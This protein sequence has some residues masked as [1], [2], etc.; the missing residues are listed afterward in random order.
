M[1]SYQHLVNQFT[2][3][4]HFNHLEAIAGWD[5]AVMMPEKGNQARS[6][7]MATL[8]VLSH[9]LMADPHMADWFAAAEAE[10]L[11]K[12]EQ[13]SLREMKRQWS[14]AVA[15]PADLV[16][17]QS[18]AGA[19][20]EHAWRHQR[21]ENDWAG[22]AANL[23]EVVALSRE[24]A[25]CRAEA[26]GLGRYDALLA[27]YEPGMTGDRLDGLFGDLGN[28]LPSMI[29]QVQEHQKGFDIQIPKGPFPISQQKALGLDLMHKLGFDFDRG[30]LDVSVHPFCGGV[31]EDVRITTRYNEMDFTHSLM[32]V[33]HETGHA[34][35]EQ[36]LPVDWMSLPVGQ[37][38]STGI[39]ESQS[40]LMEMQIGRSE[41]FLT[42]I[43]PLILAHLGDQP[44]MALD[45][46]N[47]L[48]RRVQPGKIRVDADE[49]TYPAHIM[50][51][52]EIERDLI[53]GRL[54]VD[55]IPDVWNEKMASYL[56]LDTK[57]DFRNGCMQD[58]HW[59]D[60]SFGYFP[61]Y[62]LGAMYAAQFMAAMRRELPDLMNQVAK[63]ELAP[64]RQWLAERVWNKGCFLETDQLVRE[65]TGEPLNPKWFKEHL[66]QRYLPN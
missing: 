40:L 64:L 17:A 55:H 14:E 49:V 45:N 7:A 47:L 22:F 3:L 34:S 29:Q 44:A 32:G 26:T 33:V 51:R 35:Y 10:S 13:A 8:S 54:E 65:A 60:G 18:L 57:G 61:S 48:Y 42:S 50:L 62:T 5:A 56:G 59:T 41:A 9:E 27:L 39:H 25:Q 12:R 43:H 20:C 11:T 30:R 58:I 23:K 4:Y 19:R 37:A 24:E 21:Q 53:E 38:R 6:E 1:T 28:W 66:T 63:G 15:L 31:A 46:L 36:G 52:Y 16:K 2:R